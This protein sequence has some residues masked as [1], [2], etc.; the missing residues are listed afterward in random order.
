MSHDISQF[1]IIN[2]TDIDATEP[3]SVTPLHTEHPPVE[4]ATTRASGVS[5]QQPSP[6]SVLV[7]QDDLF[8]SVRIETALHKMGLTP[9]VFSDRN[10]ALEWAKDHSFSLVIINFASERLHPADTVRQLKELTS[11][12]IILGFCPHVWLPQIRPNAIEAG[13][14]LLVA[15]SALSLRLPHFVTKLLNRTTGRADFHHI[16]IETGETDDEEINL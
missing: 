11:P 3:E 13:C 2:S 4:D 1:N 8:F 5:A 16:S 6:Q 12:P 10:R 9:H 15:N 7:I 14:D